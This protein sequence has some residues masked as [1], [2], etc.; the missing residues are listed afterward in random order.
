MFLNDRNLHTR[1]QIYIF[2]SRRDGSEPEQSG[3]QHF[4]TEYNRTYEESLKKVQTGEAQRQ[5]AAMRPAGVVQDKE[6]ANQ[7]PTNGDMSQRPQERFSS[8]PPAKGGGN[9]GGGD[10]QSNQYNQQRDT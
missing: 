3:R 4:A 8:Q 7:L 10:G 2:G 9:G 6:F 5:I 1:N